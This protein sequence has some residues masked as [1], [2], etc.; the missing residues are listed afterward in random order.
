MTKNS[1]TTTATPIREALGTFFFFLN[2][3]LTICIS[4][5]GFLVDNI[6]GFFAR[7]EAVGVRIKKRPS[8][9]QM[10]RMGFVFDP[11]GYW[12][13]I[14]ERGATFDQMLGK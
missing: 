4:H 3:V 7:A 1:R 9:G 10:R 14:L 12:I 8:D 2:F 11:D 5:I 6:D 13:E